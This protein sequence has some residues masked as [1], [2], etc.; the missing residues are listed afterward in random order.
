[1]H[2]IAQN[3][4]AFSDYELIFWSSRMFKCIVCLE[5]GAAWHAGVELAIGITWRRRKNT[6]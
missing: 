1:V 3:I 4:C 6:V 5:Q 2:V